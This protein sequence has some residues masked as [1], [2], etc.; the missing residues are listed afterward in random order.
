MKETLMNPTACL[1]IIGNEILSGR[2]PDKNLATL[3][4]VLGKQGIA[5]NEVR[6]VRDDEA[7]IIA[8]VN[9]CRPEYN[10]IFTT[11]GIGPT[12]DDITS[13]SIAKAFGVK[14]LRHPQAEALLRAH[15]EGKH[16]N[17]ASLKMADI[18]DGAQLID[19]PV[20]SAPGYYIENVYVFAG[21]PRIM[22]A[23]LDA[24]KHQLAGGTPV[25]TLSITCDLTEGKVAIGLDAIQQQFPQVEIGSYPYFKQG[26]LS[27]TI[28]L[29]AEDKAKNKEAH[30]AVSNLI[31]KLGGAVLTDPQQAST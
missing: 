14:L 21:V 12:H 8:A 16:L 13:A 15:Y 10:Y 28:V 3:A 7:A 6:I 26:I 24:V 4:D 27:T 2:T 30:S 22:Q 23:M 20:S 11:G 17:E 29:R 18:P 25:S 19:N 31:S 5:L 9:A 1:I